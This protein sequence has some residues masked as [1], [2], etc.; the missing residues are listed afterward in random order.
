VGGDFVVL[1]ARRLCF[2][3]WRN[4]STGSFEYVDRAGKAHGIAESYKSG[5]LRFRSREVPHGIRIVAEPAEHRGPIIAHEHPWERQWLGLLTLL[6]EGDTYRGWGW[7][8]PRYDENYLCYLESRDGLSWSK[9]KLGMVEFQGSRDNNL[10]LANEGNRSVFIDPAAPA[11]ERYKMVIGDRPR[12][13][14]GAISADGFRWHELAEPIHRG[15]SDTQNIAYYDST[16]RQYVLYHRRLQFGRRAIG[17]TQSATFGGFPESEIVLEACPRDHSASDDLYT[18]CRTTF[19]GMDDHHLMFPA[20]YHRDRDL[21]STGIATSA[22]GRL[23]Q[24]P[25]GSP[26]WKVMPRAW[27]SG[28]TFAQPNLVELP[29][30]T[31]VLPYL[32]SNLPHK[33]PRGGALVSTNGYAAWPKGRIIGVESRVVGWFT[34]RGIALGP[35]RELLINAV[36]KPQGTILIEAVGVPGCSMEEAVPIEGDQYRSI[37]RWKG[38]SRLNTTKEP[39][40]LRFR[41]NRAAIYGVESI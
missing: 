23:W 29:D 12:A 41:L 37:V 24:T 13:I 3:D 35:R 2:M 22:D 27:D 17:R 9:P 36:T 6:Q 15:M 28:Y 26:V 8:G 34:I 18:N 32:T 14:Y 11:A 40:V 38:T 1:P 21:A 7:C 39:V 16:T 10:L 25:D 30:G 4:I 5:S 33:Y 20:I 19:P 31:F